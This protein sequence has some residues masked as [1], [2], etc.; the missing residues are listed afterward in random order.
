MYRHFV[1][2]CVMSGAYR[3]Q[4]KLSDPMELESHMAVNHHLG[5]GTKP[6]LSEEQPALLSTEASL[7]PPG[8]LCG[9]EQMCHQSL[10][11]V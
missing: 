10:P 5:T 3:G 2:V 8:L 9:L 6:G 4:K 11:Y 1:F 7:Q